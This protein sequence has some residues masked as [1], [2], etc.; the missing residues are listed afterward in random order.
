MTPRKRVKVE[1]VEDEPY[2]SDDSSFYGDASTKAEWEGRAD[3]FDAASWWANMPLS[4]TQLADT[5]LSMKEEVKPAKLFNPLEGDL[6]ARQLTESLDE[7]LQR[8]PPRTTRISF[9]RPWIWIANPYTASNRD[10][11]AKST[12]APRED[13]PGDMESRHRF[14]TAGRALLDELSQKRSHVEAEMKG[15]VAAVITRATNKYRE[16]TVRKIHE[17]AAETKTTT[18][19]WMLFVDPEDVNA[20]WRVVAKAVA[21][22][23]LGAMAKVAPADS[24]KTR[25]A[26]LIC[27]YTYNFQDKEDVEKILRKMKSLGLIETKGKPIYYKCDAY[28]LLGITSRNPYNIKASLYASTDFIQPERQKQRY[29]KR[30]A[31]DSV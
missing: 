24:E 19:K 5:N 7:F 28:T 9:G 27:I 23:E 1:Q 2:L 12:D 21:D 17:L 25:E 18:G 11:R 4:L 22:N 14:Q 6:S 3:D 26:R 8:L 16:E 15:K 10:L 29:L 20:V 13:P 31:A 30:Q